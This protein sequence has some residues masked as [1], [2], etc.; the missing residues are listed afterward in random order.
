MFDFLNSANLWRYL[1]Y[2][3]T[4]V[5]YTMAIADFIKDNA[6]IKYLG[7]LAAI[8]IGILA[9]YAGQKE[10]ER[11]CHMHDGRHPGEFF[12]IGWTI[13]VFSFY[14]L[15]LVLRKPYVIPDVIIY[16]YITVLGVLAITMKSKKVYRKK[17]R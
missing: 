1:V 10:F 13:L 2:F 11:W 5:F 6:L 14:A 3:W 4:L 12:V 9:V 16:T 17:H 7:P 15:D 8:Y